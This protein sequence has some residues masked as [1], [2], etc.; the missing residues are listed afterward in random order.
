MSI[1]PGLCSITMRS[2]TP[3]AVIA[4][5]VEAGI[6][7]IEWGADAHVPPG[8]LGQAEA[9]ARRCADEGIAIVSY[10]SYLGMSAEKETA[11]EIERVL[12]TVE[13]LGT[14]MVRV[15]TSLGVVAGSATSERTAVHER[16]AAVADAAA[17][18]TITVAV[19]FHPGTLTET[20]DDA[21]HLLD[22]LDRPNVRVHWQPDPTLGAVDAL[23]ELRAVLPRLAHLHVFSWGPGGITDRHALADGTD[24]WPAALA[25]AQEQPSEF[26]R[27]ALCEYVRDD[28]RYQLLE[29]VSTL[30]RW[31]S[32]V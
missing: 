24:L 6:V 30:R 1:L 31:L 4:L 25:A 26:S 23:A 7:A 29:D 12:D 9:V 20:A 14:Q 21:N 5:S 28:S 10:G 11:D 8:D 3:E 17:R 13:A 27:V 22:T 18:R 32:E 19:E 15:W 2:L 16:V